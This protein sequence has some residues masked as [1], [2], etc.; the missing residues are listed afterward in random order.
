[1]EKVE[2]GEIAKVEGRKLD[3]NSEETKVKD[4]EEHK[5]KERAGLRTYRESKGRK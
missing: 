5:G 1:M 3:D 4:K 2:K